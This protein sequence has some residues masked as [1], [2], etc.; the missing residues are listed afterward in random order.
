VRTRALGVLKVSKRGPKMGD[1]EEEGRSILA[2]AATPRFTATTLLALR[3]LSVIICIFFTSQLVYTI[4]TDG[5]PFRSSLL[6]PWMVT[7]LYDFYLVLLP[8]LFLVLVRH[9]GNVLVGA[10]AC[11]FLCC[12]G[13]S[14]TWGYL[15]FVFSSLRPGDPITRLLNC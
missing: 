5:S 12:L 9:R 1:A 14:A 8:L 7:T 11:V 6:T 15:F 10:A 13:T 4:Q 2:P 3:T